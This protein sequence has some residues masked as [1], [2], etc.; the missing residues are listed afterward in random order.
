MSA[1]S[2]AMIIL[3]SK[4]QTMLKDSGLQLLSI[5]PPATTRLP[6]GSYIQAIGRWKQLRRSNEFMA[7]TKTLKYFNEK[8]DYS[9]QI[10]P[11][12]IKK[13]FRIKG[14]DL[15]T[16]QGEK[17]INKITVQ[18]FNELQAQ[19]ECALKKI[20]KKRR[21]RAKSLTFIKVTSSPKFLS[22][23]SAF[24]CIKDQY[25]DFL[26][27]QATTLE[28]FEWDWMMKLLDKQ[29]L[30]V[31]KCAIYRAVL[32]FKDGSVKNPLV[33]DNEPPFY[34][35]EAN[36]Y[37]DFEKLFSEAKLKLLRELEKEFCQEKK[38]L[39]NSVKTNL[40]LDNNERIQCMK[41]LES[42]HA[43]NIEKI[44]EWINSIGKY[45]QDIQ[46][47]ITSKQLSSPPFFPIE[48][49]LLIGRIIP[50]DIVK[51]KIEDASDFLTPTRNTKPKK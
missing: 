33:Y 12:E 13:T 21:K 30:I 28:R 8:Y 51:S 46:N 24:D 1:R 5:R 27:K 6:T 3:A 35:N 22:N 44:P 47:D 50:S 7:L 2:E 34:S 36:R 40:E 48:R 37:I 42:S 32:D 19:F 38:K 45:L 29:G 9:I 10:F 17:D 15:F 39:E 20:Q 23:K 43:I 14:A 26:R 11:G 18:Q 16:I 41:Y 31:F 49:R 4:V 25:K